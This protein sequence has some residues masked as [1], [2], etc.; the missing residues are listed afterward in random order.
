M[1]HSAG[2]GSRPPSD[3]GEKAPRSRYPQPPSQWADL[4]GRRVHFVDHGGPADG[5][6]LVLVHGLGGSLLNWAALAPRLTDVARVVAL[7]LVGFGLTRAVG[8]SASVEDDQRLLH[9][10]LTEVVGGPAIVVGNSMGGLITIMQATAHPRP[11]PAR[12]RGSR[13]A[14]GR[15]GAAGPAG[16]PCSGSTPCRPSAGRSQG[17]GG[18]ARPRSPRWTCC[19][20][21]ASTPTGS[22]PTCSTS[23]SR[24]HENELAT[25]TSTTHAHAARS[26]LGPAAH[27]RR[28]AAMLASFPTP[29]CCCRA[30]RTAWCPWRPPGRRPTRQPDLAVAVAQD[31]GHVPQ[32]EVPP[33]DRRAHPWLART[34]GAA[35][36]A[37]RPCTPRP[38]PRPP[39]RR[40]RCSS[41]AD[42]TPRSWRWRPARSSATSAA[43]AS[44]TPDRPAPLT[45]DHLTRVD[46][47][48]AA[49]RAAVPPAAGEVP[50][51]LDQPYWIDDPDFDIEFH[52]R[53]LALPAPGSDAQ[54]AEQVAAPARP[55]A[56]PQPAAVGALPDP[57]AERRPGRVYTKVHHA[58]IDGVSGNDILSALSRPDAGGPPGA[59]AAAPSVGEPAARPLWLLGRSAVSLAR[60][61]A[62]GRP[63]GDRARPLG[64]R[65]G[66]LG[67]RG[68]LAA[69]DR[70]AATDASAVLSGAGL[71]A[72][73]DAVQQAASPR[74]GA[75]PSPTCRWPR[76]RRSDAA[77]A[78]RQRRRHGAVRRAR[79]G[80]GCRT[81]TRCRRRRSSPPSRCRSAPRTRRARCGNRVSPMLAPLPTHLADP[82]RAAGGVH[83]AMRVAKEQHGAL[84]AGLL[85]DVTQFAMPAL[86]DQAWRLA[87]RLRLFERVNPF[88]LIIS[89]V[90]GPNVPLYYAGARLLA[91]YPVSAIADGQGLNITVMSYAGTL[92]FG[93]VA[94][95][96]LCPDL[97]RM[98]QGLRLELDALLESR[99]AAGEMP[100]AEWLHQR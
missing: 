65:P 51:G 19:D 30:T 5:P 81:T 79:C 48:A 91:Y 41:S 36:A 4:A 59:R 24:W 15:R 26:L 88:N 31:V 27:G 90:P 37:T 72:P 7:D 2:P 45:L 92:H 62:A 93:L 64:A 42:W 67:P 9:R 100:G 55:A 80:A 71:R 23:T 14:H 87:A 69:A 99:R 47:V 70:P 43:S 1:S 84:P 66:R 21:A 86:A 35:A 58:A 74:T 25:P 94:C 40:H 77:P 32:L 20:F 98:A 85:A 16:Q 56:R 96:E 33:L 12:A 50:F 61:P 76:S 39:R 17:G 78:D 8:R 11:S 97:G 82:R 95:R 68:P 38:A 22:P 60:A 89:N 75:G 13:T 83:Q 29:C 18:A 34:R 44:S 6:L 63:R 52:V 73:R 3:G 28:F 54:L 53:E 49:A 57:R 10:F 46:R